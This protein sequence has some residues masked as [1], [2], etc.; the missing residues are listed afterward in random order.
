MTKLASG[1]F[2]VLGLALGAAVL[3]GCGGSDEPVAAAPSAMKCGDLATITVAASPTVISTAEQIDA[4]ATQP[5]TSP[6]GGGGS[7]TVTQPFCRV[8]GSIRPSAASDIQFELWMP[9]AG[10]WNNKFAGTASGGSAGYIAYS[11][12]KTH[13]AMGYASIG[14]NNGHPSTQVNW[15]LTP[16]RKLDFASRAMHVSTLV[17]KELAATYYASGP[18][19]A[20]YNGCSQS[21]H[22]G[23]MEMQRYPE[24]YDGIIAGAPANDWTGTLAAEANAALAQYNTPGAGVPRALQAVVRSNIL[25]AC[26]GKPGIDH[27]ADGVLDDPRRCT[28][29][30]AAMQCGAPG[31]DPAACL[32]APQV[33]ALKTAQAGRR[34]STGEVVALGYPEGIGGN[35]FPTNTTSPDAP[36]GSWANHWRYA[37]LGNPTYDF[38]SFNWD[39]DVDLARD[40]EGA[41]YDA[42][43]G[44][45]SA[46]TARG[47][48]FLMYHGW[49]DS[50]I[51]ASLSMEFWSRMRAQMG[52][53]KVDSFARLFMVPGMDHCGGGSG[54]STFELMTA[55]SNW[56]ENGVAPD[57]T[58]AGNTPVATRAAAAG[59][60][61]RTRPL[62]PYPKVA[63]YKGTG[64]IDD[65]ANFSCS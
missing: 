28:Y 61:A 13:L 6:N 43:N 24:D 22:H 25:A 59:V 50:L 47:G 16:D 55:L 48:K 2:G 34:K 20:Y 12:V 42:I 46:F 8:A 26:D 10:S 49:A 63:T 37:V 35:F 14:H 4:S 62:C 5:W 60:T 44:D 33:Q 7:A 41:T 53:Q 23:I 9:L 17:G 21:G 51:P 54:T 64:S 31:A 52:G 40:K 11:S 1:R 65:A 29:D 3:S 19:H 36:Q 39:T 15:A 56:V 30:I 32:S 27:L 18:K 57:G 58:N 45:Y 38:R